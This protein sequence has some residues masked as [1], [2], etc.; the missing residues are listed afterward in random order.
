VADA[1][2]E[3]RRASPSDRRRYNRRTTAESVTPPYYEAFERIAVAL[4]RIASDLEQLGA[5]PPPV[6]GTV[7]VT[8]PAEVARPRRGSD[9]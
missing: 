7:D 8:E 3:E 1:E 4:E 2:Q 9:H 6:R 5:V